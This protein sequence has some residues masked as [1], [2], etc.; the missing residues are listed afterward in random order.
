MQQTPLPPTAPT[1]T[2]IVSPGVTASV[3]VTI[4]PLPGAPTYFGGDEGCDPEAPFTVT[5]IDVTP[6]G[7]VHVYD[8]G[9][10]QSWLEA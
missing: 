4:A 9:V 8:P 2:W 7:T 6:M 10:V 5:L 1:F 3:A